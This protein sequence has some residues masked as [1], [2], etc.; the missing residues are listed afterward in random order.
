VPY[1]FRSF[2]RQWIIPDIRVITQPNAILW[3]TSSN[4]Q[5]YLTALSRS[6]PTAGP[7][8]TFA[9]TAPDLDHY[10]GS[11]GGRVFPLWSDAAATKTNLK[12]ALVSYLNKALGIPITPED[13]FSY[14]AAVAAN[15]AYT[16]RFQPDLSTPGLRIPLTADAALFRE[17]AALGRRVLWLHTFGER[18]V[19]STNG[20][21]AGPPRIPVNPPSIP[22]A[23]RISGKPEDFP[24][25]LNY[26]AEKQRLFV[27]HGY[28]ENVSPAV[29]VYE[30]SGKNVLTQW[31]S[32]RKLHRDRPVIGDRRAPSKLNDIQP[33]HWLPEYTAELLNVLNVLTLLVGLEPA[34]ADLLDRICAGPLFSHEALMSANA[35]AIPPKPEKLK[36]AKSKHPKLF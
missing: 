36:K 29:W 21:P 11:F 13:L 7:A 5:I 32:Y 14:I 2:N 17:A 35:L 15:P 10:K 6:S 34:Q 24:D 18:L 9:A 8:L 19:D 28:I 25:T 3:N 12:P 20:R 30:V 23:G 16:A 22:L 27:G 31:F 33:D 1:A 4:K 26:D